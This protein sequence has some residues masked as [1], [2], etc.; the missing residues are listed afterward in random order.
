MFVQRQILDYDLICF[1]LYQKVLVLAV[2]LQ[3]SVLVSQPLQV[4]VK[5]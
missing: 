3:V 1:Y 4:L 2:V 5:V